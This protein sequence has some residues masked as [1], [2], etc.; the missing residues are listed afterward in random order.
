MAGLT[1]KSGLSVAAWQ[2][3]K[4]YGGTP[5]K[6]VLQVGRRDTNQPKQMF[7]SGVLRR[8]VVHTHHTTD[9]ADKTDAK[10]KPCEM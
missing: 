2:A 4:A 10:H 1:K 3:L 8:C 7:L 5:L 6:H 9:A